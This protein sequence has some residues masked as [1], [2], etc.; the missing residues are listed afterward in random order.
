MLSMQKSRK[1]E[2][3][4]RGNATEASAW[5]NYIPTIHQLLD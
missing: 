5:V 3:K 4:Y 2:S 1:F